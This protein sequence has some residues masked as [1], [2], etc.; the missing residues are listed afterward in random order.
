MKTSREPSAIR[1]STTIE[2]VVAVEAHEHI[3]PLMSQSGC[4]SKSRASEVF[5]IDERVAL[6]VATMVQR[7]READIDPAA[8]AA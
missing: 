1:T 8:E 4:H 7:S 3:W 6:G 2:R 5:D